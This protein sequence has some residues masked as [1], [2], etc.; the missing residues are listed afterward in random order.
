MDVSLL[1]SSLSLITSVTAIVATYFINRKVDSENT[2]RKEF[3]EL[4]EP[5]VEY[6]EHMEVYWRSDGHYVFSPMFWDERVTKIKRRLTPR[7]A[8]K[9]TTL[10][11]N[12]DDAFSVAMSNRDAKSCAALVKCSEK[13]RNFLKVR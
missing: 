12:F 9:F 10:I 13:L 8:K 6:L 11:K 7:Q 3:N 5:I 2:K 1:V 4:A